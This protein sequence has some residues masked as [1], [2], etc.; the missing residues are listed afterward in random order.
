MSTQTLSPTMGDEVD[1]SMT[2]A[3]EVGRVRR[4]PWGPVLAFGPFILYLCLFLGWP[5]AVV[6]L[7][8]L[9]PGGSFSL[10]SLGR[11]VTGPYRSSFL[12][13]AKLSL[14]SSL[15]GA[16]A[17]TAAA[18]ALRR[19]TRP[20]WL[21]ALVDGWAAVASQLGGV[22]LAF[23][24]IATLG[25]QGLATRLLAAVGVDLVGWGFSISE[26]SGW[27]VVYLYFQIPLMF[28]VMTPAVEG[29]RRTWEEAA[30]SIGASR[31]QYWRYVGLPLLRPALLSGFVLLFVNAFSA[32]ATAYALSSGAGQLVPLQVRFV[33][34][35]N[36]IS[37]EEDLGYALV[38]WTIALL[39]VALA[40]ITWLQRRTQRWTQR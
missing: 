18:L 6:L 40:T 14:L 35:G 20:R 37:G 17:G 22:P 13:S 3:V 28:L 24:F 7:R 9:T 12:L 30:Q 5:V 4:L 21:R 23:A 34:Q 16:A 2:G 8:A 36:V 29:L 31:W 32:Y 39:V 1:G 33:L 27:V 11:A 38:T 10:S 25:T 26:F 15:L 19:M